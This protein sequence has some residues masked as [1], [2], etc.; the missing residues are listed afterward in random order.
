MYSFYCASMNITIPLSFNENAK[1]NY[2]CI[3]QQRYCPDGQRL[4]WTRCER[5]E[6]FR[7]RYTNRK[8]NEVECSM[9]KKFFFFGNKIMLWNN[10]FRQIKQGCVHCSVQQHA[11]VES[12]TSVFFWFKI[13]LRHGLG[14]KLAL[15]ISLL[16]MSG[17]LDTYEPSSD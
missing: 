6:N 4:F 15:P 10:R 12:S 9:W 11:V 17:W 2:E 7:N 13:K 8:P 14:W 16:A 1:R 3:S 5:W